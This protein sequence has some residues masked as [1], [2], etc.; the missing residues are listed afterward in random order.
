[1]EHCDAI[2]KYIHKRI[3]KLDKFFKREPLPVYIDLI[4]QAHREHDFFKVEL[5]VNSAHYHI[6]VQS[7][8]FDMHA[9]IDE[10][11]LRMIKDI[12]KKKERYGHELH[13]SYV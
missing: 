5:K 2:E 13:L 7:E 6:M 9:M 12:T 4:L 3:E 10:A 8:G 11:V 1:M